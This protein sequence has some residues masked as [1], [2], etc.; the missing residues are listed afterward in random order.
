MTCRSF[1][2]F[3]EFSISPEFVSISNRIYL[4]Y[5]GHR[6]CKFNFYNGKTYWRCAAFK[7]LN[8]GAR[9]ISKQVN[10]WDMARIK[11]GIHSHAYLYA[12]PTPL[13]KKRFVMG[14]KHRSTDKPHT[15]D[16][17]HDKPVEPTEPVEH[18]MLD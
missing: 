2:L 12:K 18:I 14:A 5:E 17:S 9:I 11:N 16:H 13:Q 3:V 6:F 10:G 1:Y 4:I 7:K 8:C 15:A